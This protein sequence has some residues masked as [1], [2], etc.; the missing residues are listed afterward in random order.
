MTVTDPQISQTLSLFTYDTTNAFCYSFTN[1]ESNQVTTP[2]APPFTMTVNYPQ[3]TIPA[4]TA[5]SIS[6]PM[7]TYT[8]MIQALI[9][10][11]SAFQWGNLTLTVYHE[12]Y[13][14]TFTSTTLSSQ[15]ATYVIGLDP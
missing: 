4:T 9:P 12:C 11:T 5:G 3:L 15:N 2:I 6:V 1:Y 10:A 14:V 7:L 13:T 8:I